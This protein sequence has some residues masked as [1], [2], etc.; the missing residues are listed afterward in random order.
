MPDR[1]ALG[2]E[3]TNRSIS[4]SSFYN[5]QQNSIKSNTSIRFGGF[6]NKSGFFE[7]ETAG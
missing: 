6:G 3:M 5:M 7:D 1:S 2:D 4:N